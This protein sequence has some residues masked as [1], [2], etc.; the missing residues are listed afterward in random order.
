MKSRARAGVARVA[1]LALAAALAAGCGAK[2]EE[3]ASGTGTGGT[4]ATQACGTVTLN[5]NTWIGS[6]ANVYVAKHVL[7]N[8]FDCTV[9]VTKIAE[10]PAFQAMADGDVDAVLEDWQHTTEYKKYIDELGVVQDAGSLGITGHIGWYTPKYVVDEHP[11]LESWEGLKDN[12]ELFKTPESGDKGQLLDGDPSYVT[13]DEALVKN[14]GLNLKVIYAGGEASQIAAVRQAY[15]QEEPILFYWYT[16]QWLNSELEL[17]EVKLPEYTPGCDADPKK[18][19]CAYPDYDLRKL[20]S[21]E[22]A[23]SGSPAVQFIKNFEWSNAQQEE[24]GAMIASEKM[25]PE[26]AAAEWVEANRDTVD[27]WL[28]GLS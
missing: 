16:P 10:I 19:A 21:T 11:E 18:I 15:Q 17:V 25:A 6:T 5:E 8:E 26:D 7:E 12:W 2:T 1:A 9:N 23:E 22:F 28:E 4:G 3:G 14:L 27:P 13:N 24:V 20:M